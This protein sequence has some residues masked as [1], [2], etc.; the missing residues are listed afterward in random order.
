MYN[1]RG[2]WHVE[3]GALH[4]RLLKVLFD[5][6]GTFCEELAILLKDRDLQILPAPC[7]LF[8][9]VHKGVAFWGVGQ[10]PL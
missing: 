9:I 5:A 4:H 7:G 3:D 6:T 1:D 2:H 8:L 10:M